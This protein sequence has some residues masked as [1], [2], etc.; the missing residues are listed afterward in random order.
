MEVYDLLERRNKVRFHESE[1]GPNMEAI[2]RCVD[3]MIQKK[4][5]VK[6][7]EPGCIDGYQTP[8][9]HNTFR[10]CLEMMVEQPK[11]LGQ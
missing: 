9:N 2:I 10:V 6:S 8:T 5:L 1:I 11:L 4:M 7:P 3:E